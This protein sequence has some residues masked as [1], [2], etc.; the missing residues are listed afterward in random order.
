MP[1]VVPL[2]EFYSYSSDT[3]I[4][5][6]LFYFSTAGGALCHNLVV[7]GLNPALSAVSRTIRSVGDKN[8]LIDKFMTMCRRFWNTVLWTDLVFLLAY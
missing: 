8:N 4:M 7:L 6:Q 1:K 2:L 5:G 3:I